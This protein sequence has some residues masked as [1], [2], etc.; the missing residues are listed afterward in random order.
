M[1]DEYGNIG[2]V[3]GNLLQVALSQEHELQK[4]EQQN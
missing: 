2:G 4:I 1:F 3:H